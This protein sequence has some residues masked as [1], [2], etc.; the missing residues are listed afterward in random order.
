MISHKKILKNIKKI[1]PKYIIDLCKDIK[2]KFKNEF[3]SNVYKTHYERNCLI[4]YITAPFRKG[5]SFSHQ[6]SWQTVELARAISSFGYNV[7]VIDYDYTRDN[8]LK[9]YD[10]LLD[11]HPRDNSVYQTSLK[12]DCIKIAYM[13]GSNPSFS[14]NA[15]KS[16]LDNLT[17]RKNKRL[18]QRRSAAL[19]SR[20]IEKYNAMFFIG[21]KYNLKTFS[22]FKLPPVYFIKNN[23]YQL[24]IDESKRSAKNFCFFASFGQVHKG[25][26]LLLDVFAHKCTDCNLYICSSFEEEEDFCDLYNKEL[27]KTKNIFPIGFVDIKGEQFKEVVEKCSYMIMPSCSEGLAGSVITAMS[28][29]LIPIVSRECGFEDDEVIHLQDCS[30]ECLEKTVNKYSE[31]NREWIDNESMRARRIV[32]ERYT[33]NNFTESI[34]VALENVLL[35][36]DEKIERNLR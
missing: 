12:T 5:V 23:G 22:E 21:N 13:T 27:Y 34:V 11:L 3:I 35:K 6:N 20:K 4:V 36:S 33:K 24:N 7:D 15:E 26:D 28:A 17:K 31:K 29:G 32:E 10:L 14:N 9:K 16:R 8:F 19:I 30:L 1:L 2:T 18:I 25:L